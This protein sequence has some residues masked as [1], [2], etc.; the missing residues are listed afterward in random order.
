MEKP[1]Y[2][3]GEFKLDPGERRLLVGGAPVLLTPKVFDTLVLLVER[4]GHAVSKDE[5]MQALWPRGFVDESNLTKHIWLIRKALGDAGHEARC[6]ETVPKLGYRFMIPVAHVAREEAAVRRSVAVDPPVDAAALVVL[7]ISAPNTANPPAQ[8]ADVDSSADRLHAL[9]GAAAAATPQVH[10]VATS[11]APNTSVAAASVR[12]SRALIAGLVVG[13]VAIVALIA[14]YDRGRE[15]SPSPE[16]PPGT[17]VAIVAFNNLSQNAKDAWLGPALGEMLATEITASGRLHALPDEL[18][19]P[20]R[21]D[22]ATPMAGGYAPQSLA[23]LRK[24]LGADYVLSG[25]YLV[26]GS[27]D[28]P[29]LRL[30]LALQDARNGAEVANLARS[31]AVAELPALVIKAGAT[32]RD[33]LGV[34]SATS[35]EVL[36]I[37]AAQP[38]TTEVARRIGF[39]LDALHRNDPARARDELLDAVAQAPSYAPSY[40]YLA[41][42]WSALGYKAKALAAAQQATA[43][44]AGLPEQQR[45]EIEIQVREAEFNWPQAVASL[46]KLVALKPDDPEYHLQLVDALLAAGK[47]ADAQAAMDDLGKLPGLVS[48][49]ARVELAAARVA[50]ARSDSNAEAEHA[51]RAWQLAQ[52]REDSGL[53]AGAKLQLGLART[54]N[55]AESEKLMQEA[56]ADYQR[57]GNPHGE[58]FARQNLANALVDD[59]KEDAARE[60]YQRAMATYQQ[61]GDQGGVA[62]IYSNLARMLWA[63]GD[64]D[65]A[66][67]AARRSLEIRRATGDLQGQAWN[68]TA[69]AVMHSDEA[70]SD[71][72]VQEYRQAIALDEQ[73]GDRAHQVFALTSYSDVLR[74]RG[75]LDAAAKACAQAETEARALPVVSPTMTAVSECALI[76][77][78]R[79]EIDMAT[80]DFQRAQKLAKEL[81]DPVTGPNADLSFAQIDMWN[82]D[83][84]AARDHLLLAIEGFS[85]GEMATG[86]AIAQSL[87]ALCYQK[88]GDTNARDRA[89][90]RTEELRSRITALGEVF[91]VDIAMAQ[92]LGETGHQDAAVAALHGLI[93]EADKRQWIGWSLETRLALVQLLESRHDPSAGALRRA[94]IDAAT[95]HGFGSIVMRLHA[96]TKPL[97]NRVAR[98]TASGEK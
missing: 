54:G 29:Q 78:D 30:D 37:T 17:A 49:D 92:L 53:A 44:A 16:N 9:V 81:S 83:P 79:G 5:L 57:I 50:E 80:A 66:E 96:G 10:A 75:E 4:A 48:S 95:E 40:S 11:G 82:G 73:S 86:E 87:L 98:G 69:L 26:S 38:P 31:G 91:E 7:A 15:L 72:V 23:T 12:R 47:S 14:W 64:R 90:A 8:S 34:P 59:G 74:M 88:L 6:I 25:S 3:F 62:A 63:A 20:A 21:A 32:L 27:G 36:Q 60:E 70:A 76:A 33:K 94:L 35:D 61:I 24:R 93:A 55:L 89:A 84:A 85:K 42:A 97:G 77:L 58:A 41:Q 18:V 13:L 52:R 19:R 39:A 28:R 43:R 2:R 46:R 51:G 67:I 22:L 71:A 1:V 45:L 68:L 65:G 56:A